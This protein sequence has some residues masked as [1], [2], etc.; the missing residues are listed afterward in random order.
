MYNNLVRELHQDSAQILV[1]D[2]GAT[3][4]SERLSP[5]GT[6]LQSAS[7]FLM[8]QFLGSTMLFEAFSNKV[9]TLLDLLN[10]CA[11]WSV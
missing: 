3:A 10:V 7:A 4:I 1:S 11:H 5:S 6:S 8:K 2:L 9:E